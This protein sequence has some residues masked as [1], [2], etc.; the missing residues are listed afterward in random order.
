[1]HVCVP[2][3]QEA[4]LD[5]QPNGETLIPTENGVQSEETL[6]LGCPLLTI[7]AWPTE[8]RP[9]AGDMFTSCFIMEYVP[10]LFKNVLIIV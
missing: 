1:M 7:S 5:E 4:P 9:D 8:Q 10:A 6:W 3:H 2:L